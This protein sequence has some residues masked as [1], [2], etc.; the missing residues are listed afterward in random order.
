MNRSDLIRKLSRQSKMPQAQ[1]EE[2]LDLTLEMIQTALTSGDSVVIK[3]F[4]KF[5]VRDRAPTVKRNPRTGI[6][7]KVPKRRGIL[8]HPAPALKL[9][10]Q[11]EGDQ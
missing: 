10:V 9:G 1:I 7:I 8:F 3:N 11:C 5:E 6:D 2:L 4:G